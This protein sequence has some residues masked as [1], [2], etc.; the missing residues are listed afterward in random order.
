MD[1]VSVK[2]SGAVSAHPALLPRKHLSGLAPLQQGTHD[3]VHTMPLLLEVGWGAP[4]ASHTSD[5]RHNHH[6][7][8]G[9]QST[10]CPGDFDDVTG[11]TPRTCRHSYIIGSYIQDNCCGSIAG[12]CV[13]LSATAVKRSIRRFQTCHIW[14]GFPSRRSAPCPPRK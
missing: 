14:H 4:T 6:H 3:V 7:S 9:R 2:H 11:E 5:D 10:D 12:D 1:A 8:H 13:D